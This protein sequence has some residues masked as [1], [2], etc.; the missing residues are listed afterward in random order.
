LIYKYYQQRVIIIY[1]I[2]YF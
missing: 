1:L 2:Y